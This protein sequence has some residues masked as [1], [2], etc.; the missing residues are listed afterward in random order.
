M[1]KQLFNRAQNVNTLGQYVMITVTVC[2]IENFSC[3]RKSYARER[4]NS[5]FASLSNHPDYVGCFE[6]GLTMFNDTCFGVCCEEKYADSL[7]STVERFINNFNFDV[8]VACGRFETM[9]YAECD[10][11]LYGGDLYE[12]LRNAHKR[13][14]VGKRFFKVVKGRK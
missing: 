2:G 7:K 3:E 11:K 12:V 6:R 13:F 1:N 4:I 5:L 9:S 8:I 14:G 10:S